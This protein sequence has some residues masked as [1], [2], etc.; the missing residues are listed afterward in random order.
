MITRRYLEKQSTVLGLPM[1]QVG[2]LVLGMVV[3]IIMSSILKMFFPGY[4]WFNHLTVALVTGGYLLLRYATGKRHPSYL[5]SV[6]SYRLLQ[7]GRYYLPAPSR[8]LRSRPPEQEGPPAR[9]E[10]MPSINHQF[11]PD[12]RIRS[13]SFTF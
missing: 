13:E 6:L 5:A 8:I 11:T 12:A 2:L 1:S 10:R 7:K 9:P 4:R 3:L